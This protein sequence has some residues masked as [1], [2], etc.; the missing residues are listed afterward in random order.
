MDLLGLLTNDVGGGGAKSLFLPKIYHIYP[1]AM[2]LGIVLIQLKKIHKSIND[3]TYLLTSAD[4]SIFHLKTAIFVKSRSTDK[5]CILIHFYFYWVFIGCLNKHDYNF[6]YVSKI[7]YSRPPLNKGI[8][9]WNLRRH[10]LCLWCY[11][12]TQ[13]TL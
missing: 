10:K 6:D 7:N 3:I 2:K 8:L 5:N 4:I 13:I 11:Q 9:K 1:A 12:V